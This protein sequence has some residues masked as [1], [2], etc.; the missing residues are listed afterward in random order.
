MS[1]IATI[2]ELLTLSQCQYRIY[3]L[4]R[5]VEKL[6]KELFEKLEH[7]QLPHPTP[8]Q[9]HAHFAVCFWQQ[10]SASPYLWF[11]KLPLDER[12]LINQGARNHFIAIIVEALGTDLSVNPTEKQEELL[13]NNP[14]IF[15]PSQYKLA[16]LNSFITDELK[17]PASKY[18]QGVVTYLSEQNWQNWQQIGAQGITD[19]AVRFNHDNHQELLIEALPQLPNDV[20]QPMCSALENITLPLK[21]IQAVIERLKNTENAITQ[22]SMFR[23]LATSAEH[24]FVVDYVD[25]MLADETLTPEMLVILAGRCWQILA[26]KNRCLV[27]LETL[28]RKAPDM[29]AALFKDLVAIPSVRPYLF[30][31]MR[32][33]ERS[34]ALA[35]AIGT[36]FN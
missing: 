23:C 11:I 20:L 29:F 17:Q 6:S 22:Q 2:T 3:D 8:I 34:P 32:D 18:Y 31:C 16:M 36:L 1:T 30:Q 28:V 10:K 25:Q 24:P 19:F 15:T 12:G 21:V 7:N 27:F 13:K 4:G 35:K 9:G 33:T 26:D 14:Y 5:R